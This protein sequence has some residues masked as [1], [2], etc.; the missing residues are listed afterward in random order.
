[1]GES[2]PSGQA[3]GKGKGNRGWY[4]YAIVP[5][6]VEPT[7]TAK[8]VGDPPGKIEIIKH[9]D[10]AALVSEVDTSKPLGRPEDLSA[11]SELLDGAAAEAPVLPLRFGAVL[12]DQ[13]AV[14]RELLE[15]Y[16]DEFASAL[17]ELEGRAE[18]VVRGRYVDEAVLSEVLSE[19]EEA[20]ELRKQIRQTGDED[21]TRDARIRLGELVNEAISRKREADTAAVG[22]ALADVAVASNVREPTHEMDAA[23]VALLAETSKQ[24]ELEKAVSKLAKDWEGRVNVR[25]LGPMAPYDFVVTQAA[26]G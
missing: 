26:E 1:M 25:L 6:D 22:D 13:D 20:A 11:H 18:Y 16:H 10:I 15:P 7:R 4:V 2:A 12:G 19:N 5:A 17:G 8:G 21:A 24:T 14:V 3:N 23:Y 9:N